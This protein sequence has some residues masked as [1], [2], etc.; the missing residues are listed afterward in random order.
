MTKAFNKKFGIYTTFRNCLA[1]DARGYLTLCLFLWLFLARKLRMV[2]FKWT[3]TLICRFIVIVKRMMK[4]MTRI[5]QNTGMLSASKN[6]QIMA[7]TTALVAE[8][9]QTRNV[10]QWSE[11]LQLLVVFKFLPSDYHQSRHNIC[12]YKN[13]K[14]Y[15]WLNFH[16]HITKAWICGVYTNAFPS[17]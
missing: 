7:I 16:S 5:G 10:L 1:L 14:Y 2:S 6:V 12:V 17:M 15:N 13:Q 3:L 8:Y 4:Y 9:L 11:L